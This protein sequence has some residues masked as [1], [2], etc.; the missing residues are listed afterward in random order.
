MEEEPE[1]RGGPEQTRVTKQ[2]GL[3][4]DDG[5]DGDVNRISH[6]AI[7]TSHDELPWRRDRRGRPQSLQRKTGKRIQKSGHSGNDQEAAEDAGEIEPE[8]SWP[9]FP[10]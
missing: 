10:L 9:K 8:K 1:E 4:Q 5:D 7:Q 3:T 2:N 6:V